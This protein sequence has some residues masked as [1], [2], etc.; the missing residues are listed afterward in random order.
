MYQANSQV[1]RIGFK[2]LLIT[3]AT[4]LVLSGAA[5]AQVAALTTK[6]TAVQTVLISLGATIMTIAFAV[7]GY[8]MA[9]DGAKFRDVAAVFIGG[10]V[11]GVAAAL[12][13]WIVT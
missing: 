1:K 8:K 9:F 11:V 2:T 6:T 12:G 10:A 3:T 7:A 4:G 5:N 13:T